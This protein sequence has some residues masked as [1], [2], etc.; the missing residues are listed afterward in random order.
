MGFG[1]LQAHQAVD[2]TGRAGRGGGKVDKGPLGFDRRQVPSARHDQGAVAEGALHVVQDGILHAAPSAVADE[3]PLVQGR[4]VARQAV[5]VEA[6]L[7]RGKGIDGKGQKGQGRGRQRGAQATLAQVGDA[8]QH[9]RKPRGHAPHVGL[10]HPGGRSLAPLQ[11][12][13]EARDDDEDDE[14]A[15]GEDDKREEDDVRRGAQ[16]EGRMD[17]AQDQKHEDEDADKAGDLPPHVR[18]A[19]EEPLAEEGK[20]QQE[21]EVENYGADGVVGGGL[22]FRVDAGLQPEGAAHG[23]LVAGVIKSR[24]FVAGREQG[25]P[26]LLV[27]GLELFE[28]D[29]VA[30]HL[31]DPR[32]V[33]DP[34]VAGRLQGRVGDEALFDGEALPLCPLNGRQIDAGRV[35]VGEQRG[36]C[37]G[38][39]VAH[40]GERVLAAKGALTG[41]NFDASARFGEHHAGLHHPVLRRTLVFDV[42][43]GKRARGRVVGA[44]DVDAVHGR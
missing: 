2:K 10:V 21:R 17:E 35:E 13:L 1:R 6:G 28:D 11:K 42:V 12:P 23:A 33:D 20:G 25:L 43:E 32:L 31:F 40:A 8:Q 37:V 5:E 19:E 22:D 27:H 29:A 16:L 9:G 44:E 38:E 3:A 41:E 15:Q 4:G 39:H 30:H 36:V 14:D 18:E 24:E 34:E 26:R 7:D